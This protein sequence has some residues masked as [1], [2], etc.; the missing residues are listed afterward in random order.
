MIASLLVEEVF[1][2]TFHALTGRATPASS[3]HG[4]LELVSSQRLLEL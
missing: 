4:W 3:Y 2:R 1:V